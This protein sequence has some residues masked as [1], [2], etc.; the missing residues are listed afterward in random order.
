MIR[1][2]TKNTQIERKSTVLSDGINSSVRDQLTNEVNN[3]ME[4]YKMM[5][6]R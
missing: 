4:N 1:Y 3:K 5:T 6:I 2:E